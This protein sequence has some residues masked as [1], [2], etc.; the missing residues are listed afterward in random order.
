MTQRELTPADYIAML[1]RRWV[2]DRDLGG[3]RAAAR[4]RNCPVLAESIC[5][6]NL[7][8]VQQPTVPADFVR[9]VDTTDISQR[10]ASMQQQILSRSRLEPIIRQFGLYAKDVNRDFD[11]QPRCAVAE[12]N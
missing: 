5:V 12:G 1:R 9:P 6:S 4:L 10:L 7:V 2:L 3:D 11:G 8:L